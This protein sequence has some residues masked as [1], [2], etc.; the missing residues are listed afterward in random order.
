MNY[1]PYDIE[2]AP[3]LCL[4]GY[5]PDEIYRIQ[6]GY[7]FWKSGQ[8]IECEIKDVLAPL[9]R[10]IPVGYNNAKYDR[11]I[12]AA[13]NAGAAPNDI[14]NI[15]KNI[16]QTGQQP[17]DVLR[18]WCGDVSIPK[19][20][21]DLCHYLLAG[22]LKT[23]EARMGMPVKDLPFDPHEPISDALLPHV[24]TYLK[25]DLAATQ[26][27]LE[28][29]LPDIEVR[30]ALNGEVDSPVSLETKTPATAATIFLIDKYKKVC[31]QIGVPPAETFAN[32]PMA[33]RHNMSFNFHFED[34]VADIVLGTTV[35]QNFYDLV[36]GAK[37]VI[38]NGKRSGPIGVTWPK[39]VTVDYLEVAVGLG[40]LH[41]NDGAWQFSGWGADVASYYPH[42]A[43]RPGGA[44]HHM[45]QDAWAATLQE[46]FLER[47]EAKKNGDKAFADGRKLALNAGAF[48]TQ[49]NMYNDLFSPHSFLHITLS[50]QV[51]LLA[52]I[53]RLVNARIEVVSANT[54]GIF[55]KGELNEAA[56]I[57][58]DWAEQ[59]HM[60]MEYTQVLEHRQTHINSYL[61]ITP[62]GIKAKGALNPN[63]GLA[64]DHNNLVIPKALAGFMGHTLKIEPLDYVSIISTRASHIE[65]DG[66]NLGKVVQVV[67]PANDPKSEFVI[68]AAGKGLRKVVANG[69]APYSPDIPINESWYE[70]QYQLLIQRTSP[71]FNAELHRSARALQ[72]LDLPVFGTHAGQ[73]VAS[74][75]PINK[76]PFH[77]ASS[78]HIKLGGKANWCSIPGLHNNAVAWINNSHSIIHKNNVPKGT[79]NVQNTKDVIVNSWQR[80]QKNPSDPDRTDGLKSLPPQKRSLT[81][82]SK[83]NTLKDFILCFFPNTTPW[84]CAIASTTDES[85]SYTPLQPNYKLNWFSCVSSFGENGTDRQIKKFDKLHLIMLDDCSSVPKG[86]EKPTAIVQTSYNSFQYL[87]KIQPY[88]GEPGQLNGIVNAITESAGDVDVAGSRSLTRI[89]RLPYGH[90]NKTKYVSTDNPLGAPVKLHSLDRTATYTLD[91]IMQWS[92]VTWDQAGPKNKTAEAAAPEDIESHPVILAA[93]AEGLLIHGAT[94]NKRD[95]VPCHCINEENHTDHQFQKD[96]DT[97]IKIDAA[98][99]WSFHCMHDNCRNANLHAWLQ[100]RGHDVPHPLDTSW[101][102]EQRMEGSEISTYDQMMER[103]VLVGGQ[104]ILDMADGAAMAVRNAYHYYAHLY[105]IVE[106]K[107]GGIRKIKLLEE[108]LEDEKALRAKF[109][110]WDPTRPTLFEDRGIK[111][112]NTWRGLG[113]PQPNEDHWRAFLAHV[114]RLFKADTW[115]FVQWLAHMVQHPGEL[116]SWAWLHISEKTGTGRGL[117]TRIIEAVV[118][119]EH[120]S[121]SVSLQKVTGD[122]AWND[123]S[124]K[125]FL[126]VNEVRTGN[127]NEIYLDREKMKDLITI[128]KR[129]VE[130]KG[131]NAWQELNCARWLMCSNHL[132]AI[133]LDDTD[134]R[135]AVV[136][137]EDK[138][139]PKENFRDIGRRL[140]DPSFGPAILAGLLDVSL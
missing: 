32:W 54:D 115:T 98:G 135:F 114:T 85:W 27:L 102:R 28:Q 49:Q 122:K 10:G 41:T 45:N 12:L 120:T 1:L 44:P 99:S 88:T 70:N 16:I 55:F 24:M 53:E 127:K 113:S 23:Y 92:G 31:E 93:E 82:D 71:T 132:N 67:H 3:N 75:K 35:A 15:S 2:V 62:D 95:W 64:G 119:H 126:S 124:Q 109:T 58:D 18:D 86:W 21:I 36:Q 107:R 13:I 112:V 106:G 125:L 136:I 26:K 30:Q 96:D 104:N 83:S 48:G 37:F 68:P 78:L 39:Y 91:Q 60:A 19:N 134:R 118:G 20:Q 80:P 56:K 87:W 50:G 47:K 66:I 59:M 43:M 69:C 65:W 8:W 14:Y 38:S 140:A 51:C 74:T 77:G 123:L 139:A 76:D 72:A 110:T 61:Q 25:H 5:F 73:R 94:T 46:L 42:L 29:V 7:W 116:P 22:R 40:G 121:L 138:P 89:F 63:P 129:Y 137:N 17:W 52:L 133:P 79:T 57:I 101:K 105:R 84:T 131:I 128:P 103:L 100:Q 33:E 81:S 117:L 111:Y 108:W 34:W 9:K 4:V 97:G 90:N 6:N 130:A 11:Y